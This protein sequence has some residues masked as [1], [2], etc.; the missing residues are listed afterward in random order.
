MRSAFCCSTTSATE[1]FPR[2]Q[3]PAAKLC[4]SL[5]S[6]AGRLSAISITTETSRKV[7]A[8]LRLPCRGNGRERGSK[9]DDGGS[10]SPLCGSKREFC[11]RLWNRRCSPSR[12]RARLFGSRTNYEDDDE[13]ECRDIKG[14]IPW[15]VLLC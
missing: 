7:K 9:I 1:L 13:H 4:P 5:V 3:R 10:L 8:L 2:W 11:S 6:A 12:R 14:Q 15:L